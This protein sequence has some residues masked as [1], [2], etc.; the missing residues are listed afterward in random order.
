MV[1]GVPDIIET[2][3]PKSSGGGAEGDGIPGVERGGLIGGSE[4]LRK[5]ARAVAGGPER[6]S[7]GAGAGIRRVPPSGTPGS[8]AGSRVAPTPTR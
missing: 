2:S 5:P 6:A 7:R 8:R 4:A 3:I 1:D